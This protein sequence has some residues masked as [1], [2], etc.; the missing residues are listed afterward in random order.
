[1]YIIAKMLQLETGAIFVLAS[2]VANRLQVANLNLDR[3]GEAQD[4]E[5]GTGRER[6]HLACFQCCRI[7]EFSSPLLGHLKA[8]ISK[9][10]GFDIRVIRIEAGGTCRVCAVQNRP[11]AKAKTS[12]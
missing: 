9:Q 7:Q 10:T 1:M 2:L 6:V 4:G 11:D 5:T 8:E 12:H 3:R